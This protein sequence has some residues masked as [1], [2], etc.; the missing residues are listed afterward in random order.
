[1]A[2]FVVPI[3]EEAPAGQGIVRLLAFDDRRTAVGG[4][5]FWM[6]QPSILEVREGIDPLTN[7]LNLSVLIA[8]NE[9]PAGLKSVEAVWSDTV[10]SKERT[11]GLIPHPEP[12]TSA[13]NGRR[14]YKVQ[15]AIPLPKGGQ[16]VQYQV[17]V[18][19]HT[20]HTIRTDKKSLKVARRSEYRHRFGSGRSFPLHLFKGEESPI[21]LPLN[22]SMMAGKKLMYLLKFGLQ[23]KIQ[24]GTGMVKLTL[25]QMCLDGC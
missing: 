2:R 16:T 1:M 10:E 7:S 13:V 6:Y 17:V 18:T 9:G 4:K 12:P 20:N 3:P 22:L 11:V 8:D 21:H 15:T 14:W 23:K 25:K 24:I 19:D 5:K